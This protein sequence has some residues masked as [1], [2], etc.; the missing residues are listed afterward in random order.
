[1]LSVLVQHPDGRLDL[2]E[3]CV[4]VAG[5]HITEIDHE[6]LALYALNALNALDTS[7]YAL[8]ALNTSL[9]ALNALNALNTSLDALN[10]LSTGSVGHTA[11]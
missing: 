6:G 9:Y 8:N 3:E 11:L 2:V 1:V 5:D 10:A 7:L 4:H